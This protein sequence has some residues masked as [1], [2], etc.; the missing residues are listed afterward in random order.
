LKGVLKIYHSA[1]GNWG[2]AIILL[3][4]SVR[5]VLFPLTWKQFRSAQ[6][7]QLLQ[8]KIKEL[9]AKY[10][11]DKQ[12]LQQE[13]MRL[14][15]EHHVNPFA[16]CLPLLFQLPVFFCLYYAIRYTPDLRFA[17]F[18]WLTL[19]SRDPYY[20]LLIIYVAS[21]LVSTE[22]S[23]TYTSDPRQKWIMRAMPL[24]FVIV[25]LNFPSGLFVYW[26]T[27]NLWTVGQQLIIRAT[28]KSLP[29]PS[30]AK[31]RRQSRFMQAML[32]AQEQRE[33]QQKQ[34][35]RGGGSRPGPRPAQKSGAARPGQ[36]PAAKPGQTASGKPGQT[37]SGK[38]GQ[39]ASGKPGQTASGKPGQPGKSRARPQGSRPQ[40]TQ[41]QG[42]QVQSGQGG[43][44]DDGGQAQGGG[45]RQGG[46]AGKP[47]QR[48]QG[49]RS[50]KPSRQR[51]R[52]GPRPASRGG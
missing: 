19:G 5:V 12:K 29:E 8:P 50:G 33:T 30:A 22:L 10:K 24:F 43:R 39:T 31:P 18:L 42:G 13:T 34:V 44:P 36:R 15:Q 35:G 25:L 41:P 3:T 17:H 4:V 21:Q 40:G 7:M 37:A 9:Q 32:A 52:Q 26:V 46:Q 16:S 11:N 48:P 14:Y 6:H 1:T 45:Q 27:T 49:K 23:M 51:P 28:M 2:V 38:P 47:A 20:I